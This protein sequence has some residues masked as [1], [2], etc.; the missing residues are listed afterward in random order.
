VV[1]QIT[2]YEAR[3]QARL[4]EQFKG[5]E[6]INAL[7]AAIANESQDFENAVFPLFDLLDIDI[8]IGAQLD[9]IGDILTEGRNGRNDADYRLALKAKGARITASGTP[10][11]VIERYIALT[12][13]TGAVTYLEAFPAGFCLFSDA[14]I[15]NGNG[16]TVLWTPSVIDTEGWYDADDATTITESGG[17][18]S[19]L[20]DKSGNARHLVQATPAKRPTTG[21]RTL[22]GRNVLDGD[23]GDALSHSGFPINA[24][25]NIQI[26]GVMVVDSVSNVSDGIY[27]MDNLV[28]GSDFKF[29]ADNVAQFDGKIQR[30]GDADVFLAGGPFP[31]PSIYNV[32]FDKTGS[33]L[34]T[35][36]VDGTSRGTVAYAV[37]LATSM[38]WTIL[39]DKS[40]VNPIDGAFAE[41]VL[42]RDLTQATRQQIEGYLAWKWG[43]EANL[44]G[45]HPYKAAAPTVF[46]P[47]SCTV[48]ASLESV[49]PVGVFVG[50][51]DLLEL[52][53]DAALYE[54]TGST[55]DGE[56]LELTG[57]TYDGD[58]FEVGEGPSGLFLLEDGDTFYVT[59]DSSGR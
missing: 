40:E 48:L 36:R 55:Y 1:T 2:D 33:V 23:G 14:E 49:A 50:L 38:L 20:D 9:G 42:T 17:A 15:C 31:G 16:S 22:N 59:F 45:G 37:N 11:Q 29:N 13:P 47:G 12:S 41:V 21:I 19:Q 34:V 58:D 52:D 44:P 3:A 5:K 43:I 57:S 35:A 54:L 10:E 27:A 51:L 32:E 39:A 53:D 30:S 4:P 46:I 7:V 8:M 24:D 28:G 26:I 18:V 56:D 25:G 6:L